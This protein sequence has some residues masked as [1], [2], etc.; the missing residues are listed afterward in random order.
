MPQLQSAILGA[1]TDVGT[2]QQNAL[3]EI[4]WEGGKAY[5][6]VQIKN[7]TATV[8]GV[9]GDVACYAADGYSD[10][11][12]VLDKS[13]ANT[14][15]IGAGVIQAAVTGTAGTS[16][17]GWIQVKGAATLNTA[18]GGSAASG[19]PLTPGT[20]DLAL[21]KAA[22]ADSTAVYKHVCA[23]TQDAANKQVVC[24]FPF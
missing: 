10:N 6:Y 15:P 4:R 14:A 13:D 23:I 17:Y 8:A 21:T 7:T 18:L 2:T 16:Y 11:L 20:S 12:V 24:D 3:G 1:L 9:A 5:K 22:E 19:D